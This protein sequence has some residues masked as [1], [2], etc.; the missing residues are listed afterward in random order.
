MRSASG[1]TLY[2]DLGN[3]QTLDAT[4]YKIPLLME[5]LKPLIE[6]G[7]PTEVEIRKFEIIKTL[8]DVAPAATV[9]Q[10]DGKISIDFK[11]LGL[12]I[13]DVRRLERHLRDASMSPSYARGMRAFL[14]NVAANP[15]AHAVDELL[16]FMEKN[17]LPITE[18][19]HVLAWKY[20]HVNADHLGIGPTHGMIYVDNYT[21]TM[22]NS[23]GKLVQMDPDRVDSNRNVDCSRGLHV[24]THTYL[25]EASRDSAIVMVKVHP[26]H[27]IAVPKDYGHSK[28]RVCA[29]L[30]LEDTTA[31]PKVEQVEKY[32]NF[33]VAVDISGTSLCK[34]SDAVSAGQTEL[35]KLVQATNEWTGDPLP[36]VDGALNPKTRSNAAKAKSQIPGP[37]ATPRTAKVAENGKR[38]MTMAEL[39]KITVRS[40]SSLRK[41]AHR[42]DWKKRLRTD[43]L[44]DWQPPKALLDQFVNAAPARKS[45]AKLATSAPAKKSAAKKKTAAIKSKT[46]VSRTKA[47]RQR[48]R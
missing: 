28:A 2:D 36:V 35:V 22:N 14:A 4:D 44:I 12:V 10:A 1:V 38:W 6:N 3:Y 21:R 19:G 46:K 43:G 45:A 29:Y 8:A 37:T 16:D 40:E 9:V 15:R 32:F 5:A 17:D 20:V 27:F 39:A 18:D 25:R 30:V 33:P 41:T 31:K 34:T 23:V 47:K 42:Q 26:A 13:K 7:E 11:D 48:R 24:C